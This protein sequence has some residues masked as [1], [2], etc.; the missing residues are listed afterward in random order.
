MMQQTFEISGFDNLQTIMKQLPE[1]YAKK[2]IQQT[3]RKAARPLLASIK[4]G[5]PKATG[6]TRKAARIMNGKGASVSVGFSGKG[7]YMPAYFKAYWKS[8]GTLERRDPLHIFKNRR[9][10]KTKWRQGGISP[11]R[12]V[13][14]AWKQTSEAVQKTIEADLY[15]NTIK[16]L[17]KHAYKG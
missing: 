2:P 12:F 10:N 16:F 3:F 1:K 14:E 13:D 4:K 8:Y 9:K 15:N 6:Q 11:T 5:A 17:Q 7:S